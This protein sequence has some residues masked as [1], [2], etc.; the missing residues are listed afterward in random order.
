VLIRNVRAPQAHEPCMPSLWEWWPGVGD[1]RLMGTRET[2]H[3]AEPYRISHRL[4]SDAS[5]SRQHA[6]RGVNPS[7]FDSEVLAVLVDPGAEAGRAE[8]EGH[9]LRWVSDIG[10][11]RV[12]RILRMPD[13]YLSGLRWARSALRE[14]A[15]I[16]DL[17]IKGRPMCRDRKRTP[18]A[19][20]II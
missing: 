1:L 8:L 6:E 2:S 9:S 4:L 11:D 14:K 20:Q 10:T 3:R 7:P 15:P 19:T 12:D 18:S 17:C 13:A 16:R 5:P